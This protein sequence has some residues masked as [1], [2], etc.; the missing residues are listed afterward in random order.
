MEDGSAFGVRR[1]SAAATALWIRDE[2]QKIA[3]GDGVRGYLPSSIF[4]LPAQATGR[5]RIRV[6]SRP[7]ASIRG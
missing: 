2:R 5:S 7:F 3:V 6:H 4:H 1:Q